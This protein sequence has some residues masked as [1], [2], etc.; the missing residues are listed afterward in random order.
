MITGLFPRD[1]WDLI[2]LGQDTPTDNLAQLV[3][4]RR[5]E[6]AVLSWSHGARVS[7]P[8]EPSQR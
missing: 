2:N 1:G 5:P 3:R 4:A 8:V 6:V 7:Q